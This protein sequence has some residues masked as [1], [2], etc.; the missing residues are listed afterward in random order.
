MGRRLGSY[1]LISLLP[2]IGST[3]R[4]FCI[5][6]VLWV[7]E[8]LCC[9]YWDSF[10]QIDHSTLWL[11]VVGVNWLTSCQECHGSVLGPLLFLLYTS[12]LFSILEN[13][14]IGYPDDTTLMAV[15]PSPAI[16]VAVAESMSRDLMKVSEWWDLLGMKLNASKNKTMI[17]SR[18]GTMHHKSPS[19]TI[20]GTVLKESDGLV[21]LGV[22]FDSKMIF[23][24]QLHC[25][26]EYCSAV[27][28]SAATTHLRLLDRLVSVASF[29]TGGVFECD[30]A[31]RRSVAVFCM[32]YRSGVTG[33]ALFMVL[34]LCRMRRCGLHAALWLH[35]GTPVGLLAAE[36]RSI[37]RL[38]FPCQ[39]LYGTILVTPCSMVWDWQVSRAGPI[40]FYWPNCSLSFCL[41]LFSLSLL[42]FYERRRVGVF[43]LI[44]CRLLSPNLAF[45][46]F[47]N[48]NTKIVQQIFV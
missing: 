36:P 4:E 48:N 10:Y 47:F 13:K 33:C 18:S 6:S 5:R 24:K 16:R 30:L 35:I 34:F 23:E 44:G 42:S 45:P 27:W 14:L 26:L 32:L 31:H 21:I 2:L 46:T 7:L 12:E 41:L 15:V 19:L 39:Y 11:T 37:A 8:V 1:R 40:P 43:G 17:V 29:L 22:I 9:L 20:G 3:V 25:V 28:C 38:S